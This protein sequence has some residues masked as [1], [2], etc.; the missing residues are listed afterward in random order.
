MLLASTSCGPRCALASLLPTDPVLLR[1][2]ALAALPALRVQ[3]QQAERGP[4][5]QAGAPSLAGWASRTPCGSG[6][7]HDPGP[8]R[9]RHRVCG[10]HTHVSAVRTPVGLFRDAR[11]GTPLSAC[12]PRSSSASPGAPAHSLR[13]S[14]AAP[15]WRAGAGGDSQGAVRLSGD[16]HAAWRPAAVGWR[17]QGAQ[18]GAP[19]ASTP[20]GPCER[21]EPV[22]A[23]PAQG[24]RPDVVT[25][26]D[27]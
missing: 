12:V 17:C 1:R 18:V 7:V 26:S 16:R 4:R 11:T 10:P 23:R 9:A 22:A 5:R 6:R 27:R 20:P 8:L 19:R 24:W 21:E 14:P 13:G 15:R 3:A 25:S 2:G